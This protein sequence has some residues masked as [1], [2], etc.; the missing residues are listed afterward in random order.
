MGAQKNI[1]FDGNQ[2]SDTKVIFICDKLKHAF[3]INLEN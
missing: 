1:K 2:T 3:L